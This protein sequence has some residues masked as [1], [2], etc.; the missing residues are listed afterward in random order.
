VSSA[1]TSNLQPPGGRLFADP[2]PGQDESAFTVDNTTDAYE[3]S[4][5]YDKHQEQ[6]QPVPAPAQNPPRMELSDVLGPDATDALAAASQLSFH[7][8]GDTGASQAYRIKS[9]ASVAD[10]MAAD[11]TDGSSAT[12][13]F[14]FHLGDVV[15]NFGEGQYYYD[16]FYEP[17]RAYDRPI[18]AIPGNHDGMV[19]DPANAPAGATLQ[20][21]LRN[22]CAPAAGA[23]PDAGGIMRT[24]MTQPG[25]FFTLHA[26]FVYIIGLYSNVLEG[27]GVISSEGGRYAPTL[28]DGQRQF[29]EDE[30]ARVQQARAAGE[31][32]ALILACHHPPASIDATHGGTNGFT[33]DLDGAFTNT[34]V[35]PDAILSGH[36][37]LYQRYTRNRP[38]NTQIPYIVAGSGGHNAKAPQT[39]VPTMPVTQG[40]YTLR[41]TLVSFGYCT[42]TIDMT[43]APG[44]LSIRW[45]GTDGTRDVVVVNLAS[46]QITSETT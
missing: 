41:N 25:V 42:V 31:K 13:A 33:D 21:F 5:Y 46:K 19:F 24:T 8:V 37:H 22:F 15:Y 10:T 18:F 2:D 40:E 32:C 43:A 39:G 12:P 30:L 16:Q 27:P 4:I 26:P 6:L 11:I 17:F 44:N 1:F 29:L 35:W 28:D 45:T 7:T 3:A 20:A 38:D 23:S 36:A 14:L 34:G 9:E